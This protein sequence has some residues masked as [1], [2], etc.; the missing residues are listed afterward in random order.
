ML[1]TS[2]TLKLTEFY[3]LPLSF[4]AVNLPTVGEQFPMGFLISLVCTVNSLGRQRE[5]LWSKRQVCLLLIVKDLGSVSSH[6]LISFFNN[7]IIFL[8]ALIW[9]YC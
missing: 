2:V 5:C 6:K 4:P 7:K 1:V 3:T 8:V 9:F